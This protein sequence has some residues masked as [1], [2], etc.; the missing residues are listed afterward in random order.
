MAGSLTRGGS[1]RA[2][3]LLLAAGLAVALSPR[4][5]QASTV[6]EELVREARAHEAAHEDDLALR[7]YADAL[8]LDP[9]LADAYLGLGALRFR[10]GD[11]REAEQ[12]YAMALSHLPGLAAA[13]LARAR[14][15]RT[16]GE[17]RDADADL[18]AYVTA[19]NDP[20]AFR[21]LAGWYGEEAR[22][23]AQLAVWRRLRVV[24]ERTGGSVL[25]EAR[26]TVRALEL[27]V[28][29]VD[30]VRRPPGESRASAVRRGMARMERRR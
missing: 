12:V 25:A 29:P 3:A 9:T 14:V 19:T 11:A 10:L 24:A 30:P 7:R 15:R 21:E 5:A 8:A 17:V 18:D 6:A 13:K 1:R 4:R 28:G 23:L 2:T 22:P 26:V 27:I 16:L 20:A